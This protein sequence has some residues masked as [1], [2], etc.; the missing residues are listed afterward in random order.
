M[1][2]L[3]M[4][5]TERNGKFITHLASKRSGL[6]EFEVV[7]ITG[8]LLANQTRLRSDKFKMCSVAFLDGLRDRCT[9]PCGWPASTVCYVMQCFIL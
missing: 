8:H 7:R 5:A 4:S 9:N 1:Q 3:V 2:L 6:G